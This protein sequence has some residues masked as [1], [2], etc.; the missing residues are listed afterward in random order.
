MSYYELHI[1]A[2]YE[3]DTI[4]MHA[5]HKPGAAPMQPRYK[6][7]AH[8]MQDEYTQPDR[9]SRGWS[10]NVEGCWEFPSSKIERIP[11]FHFLFFNRYYSH[12]HDLGE[13]LMGI[14]II[15][16]CPSLRKM[17]RN[18]LSRILIKSITNI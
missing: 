13:I 12:I 17:I 14:F 7:Y 2:R 16:W 10:R 3:S 4:Q 9:A 18:E 1:Q 11:N 6:P 8:E 15:F 5:K